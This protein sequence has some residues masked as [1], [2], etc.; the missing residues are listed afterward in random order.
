MTAAKPLSILQFGATGQ[1]ARA[2]L[3]AAAPRQDISLLALGRG[4]VDL[5][6]PDA[7]ARVIRDA[8]PIDAVVNAA[9]YTAVDKAESEP[10]L[11]HLVNTASVAAMAQA[12]AA[13]G[14]PLV[15]LSTDYVFDG[16][17]TAPYGEGD[18]TAPLGVYGRTK[19]AGED[20]IRAAWP[21]HAILRTSWVYSPWG[22]N[23]VK[24]MLRLGAERDVLRVVDDQHGAP[25]AAGDIAQAVLAIVPRL[26]GDAV[27]DPA[28]FGTFHYAAAGETTW[29]RFAEAIFAGS[30]SWSSA[31]PKVV[32]IATAE[33]PT[34]ARR[35]S[36]SRLDCSKIERVYAVARPPWQLAL[37]GVLEDIK[38][39]R[40]EQQA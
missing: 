27:S 20:A 22:T 8:G 30:A 16:T 40:R 37:A 32:P 10:E 38:A 18:A 15:H 4:D 14:V 6:K 25:T 5:T 12:C 26:A 19:L 33:Y 23:F 9:A 39:A 36:N 3:R 11:A 17:K 21:K 2:L 7:A 31:A 1:V 34:P 28:L 29:R 24:T 13:R 35:P